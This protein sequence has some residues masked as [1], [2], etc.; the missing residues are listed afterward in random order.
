M[1]W[2]R[3]GWVRAY[4]RHTADWLAMPWQAR[5]VFDQLV[6]LAEFAGPDRG[7]VRVGAKPARAIAAAINCPLEV[8][9]AALAELLEDGCIVRV[10]N[11]LR[12]KNYMPAQDT[13]KSNALKC[14]DYRTAVKST[15]KVSK[16]THSV[17][18]STP[19]DTSPTVRDTSP[20]K[21]DTQ[22]EEEETEEKEEENS[23]LPPLGGSKRP[24]PPASPSEGDSPSVELSVEEKREL[25]DL[26][27]ARAYS[28]GI[29]STT[30][31]P[32]VV[33]AP[34][35]LVLLRTVA[36]TH[37]KGLRGSA[38]D[39]WFRARGAAYAK[40][41]PQAQFEAGYAVPRF[42]DWLNA[43]APSAPAPGTNGHRGPG[44]GASTPWI[45]PT[46]PV[47]RAPP[48]RDP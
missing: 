37:A 12:I 1:Q 35:H 13:P 48:R 15:R 40:A 4:R 2:E 23:P 29:A 6:K 36:T 44:R 19:G 42:L 5:F 26:A 33:S 17:S 31:A 7:V 18:K 28:S 47:Y 14:M 24:D 8:V 34:A 46:P 16:T 45:D 11:G 9:E 38:L 32:H 20:T 39:D 30:S 3:E 10:T 22:E 41:R 21:T 43:G 25:R 27:W